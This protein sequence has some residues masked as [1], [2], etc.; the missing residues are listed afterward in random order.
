MV[1]LENE[2][3]TN[4][5]QELLQLVPHMAP[6]EPKKVERFIAGVIPE[7]RSILAGV[8]PPNMQEA[9]A[10]LN[11]LT[12][13]LRMSGKYKEEP[14]N[15]AKRKSDQAGGSSGR[16]RNNKRQ[17]TVKNFAVATVPEVKYNGPFPNCNRCNF[18]HPVGNCPRCRKCQRV[19]HTEK[20]C[21]IGAIVPAG[22]NRACYECG[23]TDHFRNTCPRLAQP[24]NAR[25]MNQQPQANQQPRLQAPP[26]R[27]R[28]FVIGAEEARQDP[29]LV[30]GTFLING[31]YAFIL[32]DSGA[33]RSFVSLEF[34]PMLGVEAGR[35]ANWYSVEYAN[36]QKYKTRDVFDD[37]SMIL[38]DRPF[39]ISL[40]PIEI[41][42]FDIIVGMD[43]LS[44]VHADIGCFDKVVRIPIEDGKILTV[45]GDKVDRELKIVSAMKMRKYLKRKDCH[46]FLAHVIDKKPKSKNIDD[47]PIVKEY[48]DVFPDDLP[49]IP[50]QRQVEFRIDLVPG[51]APIAKTPYRLAPSEMQELSGQLQELLSK[52]FIRPSSSPWGAPILFV[53]KKD[54]SMR[55]CIDYRELNKLTVKN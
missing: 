26:A 18:H 10:V 52:G 37:C 35:L 1:G 31:H 25:P 48:P 19:G 17:R 28:A 23:S 53:K 24:V 16:N 30:V 46:A 55:M 11:V 34:K 3:Y 8:R 5:Y 27:G 51:A 36:G 42:S 12:H 20:Y 13:D 29:H 41:S 45:Q 44:K 54:G 39:E 14:K 50:P 49:G 32:F 15:D 38:S 43:W 6:D 7:V 4:R 2:V 22:Q 33:E 21:K 47:V 40:I 9:T